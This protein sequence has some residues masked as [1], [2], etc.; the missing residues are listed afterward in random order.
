MSFGKA[1]GLINMY[2]L[3]TYALMEILQKNPSFDEFIGADWVI[4]DAT[5]AEFYMVLHRT[6]GQKTAD[7]WWSAFEPMTKSLQAKTWLS[8]AR[9]RLQNPK[10]KLSIYD[11]L[12]YCFAQEHGYLF[13]TG[14]KAF[15]DKKG[16][17]YLSEKT[18]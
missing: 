9:L 15:K 3:D 18:K 6:L 11:C 7:Y 14:D 10:E 17:K 16:V 1:S 13:V 2:C 4:I 8:A 5:L 12:G